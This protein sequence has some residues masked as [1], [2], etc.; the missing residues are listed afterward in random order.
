MP[1]LTEPLWLAALAA[2]PLVRWLHRW[3]APLR[4]APVSA[5]FLWNSAEETSAGGQRK[6]RP[7]PAWRRRALIVA[8]LAISLAGPWWQQDVSR[9]TVWIDDSLSMSTLEA[10]ET[11]LQ[12][13]LSELAD[14]LGELPSVEA[15]LRS[16]SDP[17]R[18]RSGNDAM[19]FNA[20]SW[21]DDESAP[22]LLPPAATLDRDAAH[23]LVTDGADD[24]LEQWAARAPL[25]RII[26]VGSETE[27]VA[28]TQL[29]VRRSLQDPGGLDVL[30]AVSNTGT[31][32]AIRSLTLEA[33][34]GDRQAFEL[35]LASGETRYVTARHRGIETA[36]TAVL[37]PGDST[38]GDD[39]L[40]LRAPALGRVP[41]ELDPDC[42][43][44]LRQAVR[45]HSG[46]QVVEPGRAT[47][48]Q[49]LCS[50]RNAVPV[51]SLRFHGAA[52]VSVDTDPRW[53]PGIGRLE[54]LNLP[55]GWIAA[56][57]WELPPA[58]D[59][60][61]VLSA[62][63]EPLI[64]VRAGSPVT[65]EST[66]DMSSAE[67][68][69]QPEYPVLISGLVDLAL[70]RAA[71]DPVI[72][73]ARDPEASAIAPSRLQVA[74]TSGP[75]F[76]AARKPLGDIALALAALVLLLDLVFIGRASRAARRG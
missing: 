50:K 28:L 56:S 61:L 34:A 68:A 8:L 15:D 65:V 60:E 55:A 18:A 49:L 47:E 17:A 42:P 54:E 6:D 35:V 19:A 29:A 1:G 64:I 63:G 26:S 9:I 22:L 7:D 51:P 31:T 33:D 69:G 48:L 11:R 21:L 30:V 46:L 20:A 13:G 5:A 57:Q 66:L 10:G 2:I 16:L 3:R 32:G 74:L 43:G 71:L 70:G 72:A 25:A 52:P 44:P 73:S 39:A 37:R 41:V 27:N 58:D 62:D 76:G 12:A 4:S 53:Q 67:F 45:A 14:A 59:D 23:W 75:T 24:R 40:V 36:L 38:A